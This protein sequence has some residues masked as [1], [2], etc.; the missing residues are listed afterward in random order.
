MIRSQ[1]F[2]ETELWTVIFTSASQLHPHTCNLH[3][4]GQL[5]GAEVVC[6]PSSNCLGPSR[7]I[8]SFEGRPY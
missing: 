5:E 3:G 1:S 6:F 4:I 2:N 7:L 8:V